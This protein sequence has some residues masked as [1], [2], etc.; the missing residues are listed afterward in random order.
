MV[1]GGVGEPHYYAEF[2]VLLPG[3]GA[4]FRDVGLFSFAFTPKVTVLPQI[5]WTEYTFSSWIP[6]SW[7]IQ[8]PGGW[9]FA[10][11]PDSQNLE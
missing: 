11:P 8:A 5:P 7:G 4:T 6:T 1:E 3:H 9:S 10:E 2:Q